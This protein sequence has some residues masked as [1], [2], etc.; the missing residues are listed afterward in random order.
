MRNYFTY[1]EL[2]PYKK[3]KKTI[4]TVC[5]K[6]KPCLYK[7]GI[8]GDIRFTCGLKTVN[9]KTIHPKYPIEFYTF[10]CVTNLFYS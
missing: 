2:L 6:N 7:L 3:K 9:S 1:F 4:N 8:M 10:A 5:Q